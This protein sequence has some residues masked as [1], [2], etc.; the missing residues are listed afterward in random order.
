[1]INYA[2]LGYRQCPDCQ[3]HY[4]RHV[5]G[6]LVCHA[7]AATNKLY[8]DDWRPLESA[9]DMR[10]RFGFARNVLRQY[11]AEVI[12]GPAGS[13]VNF[14][15]AVKRTTMTCTAYYKHEVLIRLQSVTTMVLHA[16]VNAH[17]FDN[18]GH[19][20]D[21]HNYEKLVFTPAMAKLIAKYMKGDT[22]PLLDII[23]PLQAIAALASAK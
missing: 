3:G 20:S 17:C 13:K 14:G 11:G 4:T 6:S 7:N 9:G 2:S 8:R 15:S 23:E 5:R 22:R 19:E 12:I 21:D 18:H 1:M 16:H 10:C